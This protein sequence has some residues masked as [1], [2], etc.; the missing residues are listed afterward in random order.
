MKI[1][2]FIT[3]PPVIRQ[4]LE[5]LGLWVQKPLRYPPNRES[6]HRSTEIVYESFDD[7]WHS[8]LSCSI[9]E[10]KVNLLS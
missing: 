10:D 3:N 1:I 6:S 9:I 8:Q 7:G 2:S 5:H 4:I